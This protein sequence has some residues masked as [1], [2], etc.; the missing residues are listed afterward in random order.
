MLLKHT[1]IANATGGDLIEIVS[2][3]PDGE[4]RSNN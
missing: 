3:N 2:T 1:S 4:M